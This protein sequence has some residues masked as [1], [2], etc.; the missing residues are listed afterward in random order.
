MF[1]CLCGIHSYTLSHL[2]SL[3]LLFVKCHF[4]LIIKRSFFFIIEKRENTEKKLKKIKTTREKS[5]A[6]LFFFTF[7]MYSH[8][9]IYIYYIN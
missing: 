3:P 1:F 2:P 7:S 5:D 8:T 6:I 9:E 4:P